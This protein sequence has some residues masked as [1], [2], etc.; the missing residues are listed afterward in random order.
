MSKPQTEIDQFVTTTV[1]FSIALDR[2]QLFVHFETVA[3]ANK[4]WQVRAEVKDSYRDEF[5]Q[6]DDGTEFGGS[7]L[8]EMPYGSSWGRMASVWSHREVSLVVD[9]IPSVPQMIPL[10]ELVS[11]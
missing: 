11:H 6:C 8:D 4:Q 9:R 7:Y 2:K 10:M 5:V 3:S 1:P